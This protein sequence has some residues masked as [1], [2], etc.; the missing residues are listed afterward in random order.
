[1]TLT[2]QQIAWLNKYSKEWKLNP[3]TGLVDCESVDCSSINLIKLPVAFGNVSSYFN[4]SN[5]QL[6]SLVGAPKIVGSN[7]YCYNNQL[8]SL[9]GAPESVGG[10]FYCYNN[11]LTSLAGAPKSV[12]GDFYCYNNQLTSLA[13]AP[14]SV[15]GYFDC[16]HN[17]L[18]FPKDFFL[19][20]NSEIKGEIYYETKDGEWSSTTIH[21]LTYLK[22]L[23]SD[24]LGNLDI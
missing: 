16:S 10:D 5:N 21:Q 13:G 9:V 2:K 18:N 6:T 15:G 20:L 14:K 19:L 7:F 1:M 22:E 17:K 4:C 24:L 3:E 8:T 11:Q 23:Q 12:G